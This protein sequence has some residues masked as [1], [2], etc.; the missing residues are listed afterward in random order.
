MAKPVVSST[1]NSEPSIDRESIFNSLNTPYIVFAA[2]DPEFTII[3]ENQAHAKVAMV[4]RERTIGRPLLEAFPDTSEQYK[5]TGKSR[6]IE[7]IRQVIK[8]KQSASMSNLHYDLRDADGVFAEKHWNVT[9]HPLFGVDGNVAAVYQETHDVTEEVK[10]GSKMSTIE[11]RLR[12]V[13]ALSMVGTWSWDIQKGKVYTDIN[14]AHMFGIDQGSAAA[15][16]PLQRFLDSIHE[17]D[18][19]RVSTEIQS[20]LDSQTSYE[21]EYRTAPRNG[22]TR[23]LLAR[24]HIELDEHKKPA[25]FYGVAIDITAQK[26]AESAAKEVEQRLLFMADS[27]PQLV[28]ITRPD[29]YHEYYNKQWYDYTGTQPG[30]TDGAGWNELFHPADRERAWEV[31][32]KCLKTGEPYEIEY[33][34]YNA[35]T[36]SYRWVIGRALPFR[37]EKGVVLKWYGTCTDI[38]EQ[39]RAEQIQTF[40]S[41]TSKEM[42]STLSYKTMLKTIT[43]LGVPTLADWCSVDMYDAETNTIEQV[44]IAHSDPSRLSMVKEYRKRNP[45]EL[46]AP[47][48]VPAVLRTGKTEFYPVITFEMIEQVVDDEETLEFMRQLDLHSLIVAPLSINGKVCGGISFASSDSGRY[49]TEQDL[50][51][52]NEL[53]A[54][55]SLAMTNATLYS[56]S[57]KELKQRRELEKALRTEKESLESRVKERTA[58]LRETNAGLVTEIQKRQEAE[59]ALKENSENLARSNREL[60]DFAYVASHDLQEPLRKIRAFSNLLES[61]YK[62]QL[63]G[64]GAD[65]IRRM[66]SAAE[67]MSTLIEDL[68]AFS[69]VTTRKNNPEK[70]NLNEIVRDVAGDLES[71]VDEVEGQITIGSLPEITADPTHM[72]Q[73]FQNLIG[74]ALKFH[75]PDEKPVVVVDGRED[76]D[77]IE[78]RVSDNGIGFDE[79]YVDKI[80]SVFQRLHD[81]STYEGTGIGLAVC[82]KIAERYNGTI[83]ATSKKGKGATFIVR[84]PKRPKGGVKK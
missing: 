41:N 38:D 78:L 21:S 14:L 71:R 25:V 54:R 56:E 6:L 48:G 35:P 51:M 1:S 27:M 52:V 2:N 66:H 11:N 30:T 83:T 23:W 59:K 16:L 3:E 84:L 39:K 45:T 80:F 22:E 26:H 13:L 28:W 50:Q 69:R 57:K 82:R 31:W 18:R 79:K 62:D 74:N 60:E 9:H 67:R 34:L 33:R 49:Y 7:S 55:I 29:G 72:R 10:A 63:G 40:L 61:E 47:T 17:S 8:T 68:L 73:L 43:Q 5:K 20:A 76:E 81:K 64:E 70:I 4:Q 75:K 37:D 77:S 36:K 53:A 24:G 58:L 42:A 15:G 44:S 12:Q 46:D 65:Y 32:R 19:A